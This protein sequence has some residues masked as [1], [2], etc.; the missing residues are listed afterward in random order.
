M[1]V[2]E[3]GSFLFLKPNAAL[4]HQLFDS[5]LKKYGPFRKCPIFTTLIRQISQ[6]K[7]GIHFGA[8][9][10]PWEKDKP[11]GIEKVVDQLSETVRFN[12]HV[13]QH[14]ISLHLNNKG[15]HP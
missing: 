9:F 8:L 15:K 1:P 5:L 3:F 11:T 10:L 7:K 4:I 12:S 6:L 14:T 13:H 2:Y